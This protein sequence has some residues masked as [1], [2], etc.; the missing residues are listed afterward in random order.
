MDVGVDVGTTVTKAVAFD[1]L[2]RQVAEASRPTRLNRPGPGRFEHD[3][4]EIVASVNEVVAELT[5]SVAVDPGL[6]AITA[7][8]DGLWLVDSDGRP[9]RPAISW[10]DAR[11]N[12]ILERWTADGV[13]EQVFRRSG[14]RMFPGAS[15]PL[16][17]AVLAEEPDVLRRAAT[18]AYCKDVVMQRLTGV[19]A[20]DVSDGS[21]PFL[22]PRTNS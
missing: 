20:T 13:A 17:A 21:A 14:N 6:L 16:L 10:L 7:Q 22:D 4:D 3:T 1:E 9:V 8:G 12:M 19:R 5:A 18:A 2:G 15:G 11:S